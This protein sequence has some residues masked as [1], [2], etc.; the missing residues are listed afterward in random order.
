MT[1]KQRLLNVL[2]GIMPD[3]VP[4]S[5]FELVGHDSGNFYNNEPSYRA[6]MDDIR[7][8]TDCICLWDMTSNCNSVASG[9][10][11]NIDYEKMTRPDGHEA[12]ATIRICGRELTQKTRI[13]DGINTT[14]T[15]EH[16]CK[17]SDDVD[18]LLSLPYEPVQYN[19][20]DYPRIAAEVG[21]KGIIMSSIADPA[22]IAMSHMEFGDS[23]VW[24]MTET[25][26]FKSA[27]ETLHKRVMMN[28]ERALAVHVA[29]LYFI[30][31]P[32]Y[33]T[34]PYLPPDYFKRFMVPYLTEM[35]Q[36]IHA[37]GSKARV[38]CHGRVGKVLDMIM[39]TGADVIEPCE[40]P[41]DGDIELKDVKR[42]VGDKMTIL[43]NIQLKLLENGTEES[44][45]DEVRRVMDAA[46]ANGRFVI[47]PTASPINVPLSAHTERLYRAFV[48]A[49][50]EYGRY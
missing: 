19:V 37:N 39:E 2:N 32:E 40:G 24:A 38:H 6:L 44:V 36:L 50:L 11:T 23:L 49:A 4:I 7:A 46:K 14:W 31:G 22:Y 33:M 3:R 45:R 42:R 28:L 17:S 12:K 48:D 16:W 8:R 1:S 25:E 9:Y 18:L 13:I 35:I 47:M 30:Y 43:G 41:P 26:H 10:K 29:D 21:E 20:D 5:T 27:V 15:T 34:P